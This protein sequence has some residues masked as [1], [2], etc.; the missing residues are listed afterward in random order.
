M[1]YLQIANWDRWQTYRKDRGQ[2]PWIKIH[3]RLLRNP[4]WVSLTDGQKGQLVCLWML[5]GDREGL[6][7]DSAELIKKMCYLENTPD[8][9]LFIS[10]GFIRG[11][12]DGSYQED[13]KEDNGKGKIYFIEYEGSIKI[14]FSKNPWARVNA[15]KVGMPKEPKL[16]ANFDGTKEQEQELHKLFTNYRINREWYKPNKYLK[17]I[18]QF[19]Y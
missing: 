16:L 9:D 7:P 13:E 11:N 3:R 14:G 6:I 1:E 12:I 18:R 4:E 8:L 15:L 10:L 17:T 2:P 19:S 5:A